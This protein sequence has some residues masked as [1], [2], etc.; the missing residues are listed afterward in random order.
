TS[1]EA[2]GASKNG[3]VIVGVSEHTES[4]TTYS[5]P[6]RWMGS[7]VTQLDKPNP[8]DN[9]SATDVSADGK[10]IVGRCN[11]VDSTVQTVVR[12]VNGVVQAL[13]H[14]TDTDWCYQPIVSDDGSTV[15]S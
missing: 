15:R 14:P 9:C 13:P 7:S 10:V 8:D 3:D 2:Y 11:D 4:G 12:W 1:S 6:V 5:R